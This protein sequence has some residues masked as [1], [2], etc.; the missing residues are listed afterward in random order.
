MIKRHQ[1]CLLT[2]VQE[3]KLV[4]R[5]QTGETS[6]QLMQVF[7]FK[8]HVSVLAVLNAYGVKRRSWSETMKG[9]QNARKHSLN[10]SFFSEIDSELKAYFLGLLYADGWVSRTGSVG[11]AST[12]QMLVDEFK[13]AIQS[14]VPITVKLPLQGKPLHQL[15]FSCRHMAVDLKKHGCIPAKSKCLA[16]PKTVPTKFNHHFV[17]GLFDGDGSVSASQRGLCVSLC[18]A[19]K[20]INSVEHWARKQGMPKASVYSKGNIYAVAY[21]GRINAFKWRLILYR[22]A[23]I[24]L[25]RKRKI[26]FSELPRYRT[27]VPSNLIEDLDVAIKNER[28]PVIRSVDGKETK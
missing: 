23:T 19:K 12:D 15:I 16:Y 26:L 22:N 11:L 18:G 28:Y 10:Q 9:L 8:S 21:N 24:F 1:K 25:E 2:I 13:K 27:R 5:Y 17:R 4:M 14:S 6:A 3:R 20:L 7:G